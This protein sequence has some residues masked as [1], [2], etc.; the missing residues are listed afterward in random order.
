MKK[1]SLYYVFATGLVLGLYQTPAEA[2]SIG[3]QPVTQTIAGGDIFSVDVVISG[4]TSASEIV[5]AFDLDVTYDSSILAATGITFSN[6]LGNPDPSFYESINGSGLT[7][8]RIDFWE[9]SLLSDADLITLQSDSFSLATLTFQTFGAGATALLFDPFTFPGIDVKGLLANRLT[10]DVSA[11]NVT[12]IGQSVPSNPVS[13]PPTI[14]LC[15]LGLG[16]I[17]RRLSQA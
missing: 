14:W 1:S 2:I 11:G 8:G 17:A 16:A 9:V 15:L 5:S 10:L 4:L 6:L 3:F 13:E 7:S 12:V